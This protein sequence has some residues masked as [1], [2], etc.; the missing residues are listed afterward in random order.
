MR[1]TIVVIDDEVDICSSLQE[2][3][4]MDGYHVRAAPDGR[5]GL[6]LYHDHQVDLVITDVLMP[7]MDGL[8]VVRKIRRLS[9]TVPIIVMSGGGGRDLDFLVEAKEFGATRTI[10]KPFRLEEVVAM[11]H[12]LLDSL[13]DPDA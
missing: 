2:R 1:S 8:E 5:K 7:E 6:Q 9:S 10:S 13:S 12:D 3:L 4:T 11:V